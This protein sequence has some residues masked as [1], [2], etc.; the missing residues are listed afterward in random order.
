MQHEGFDQAAFFSSACFHAPVA[1][2][3][4][5][6]ARWA[7]AA[8]ALATF[9]ALPLQADCGAACRARPYEKVTFQGR[10]PMALIADRWAVASSSDWP[11]D[12]KA[13]PGTE[14]GTQFLRIF[15]VA[16]ATSSTEFCLP[17]L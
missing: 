1:A 2:K 17:H 10:L 11:P 7:K 16:A 14:A 3:E 13:M 12:R 8:C 15:T 5:I 4:F 9:S 6:K